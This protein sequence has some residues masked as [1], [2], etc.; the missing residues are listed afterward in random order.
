MMKR[1]IAIIPANKC[2]MANEWLVETFGEAARN[3]FVPS[4]NTSG[5]H[6][7][8]PTH[9]ICNWVMSKDD[10]ISVTNELAKPRY[11]ADW[12]EGMPALD[13][14]TTGKKTGRGFMAAKGLRHREANRG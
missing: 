8:S 5:K 2:D 7:D 14:A 9:A 13:E 3:T 6:K 11:Q 10:F 12:A 1:L 4:I